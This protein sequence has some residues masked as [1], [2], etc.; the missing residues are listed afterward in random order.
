[1]RIFLFSHWL[2]AFLWLAATVSLMIT[3]FSYTFKIILQDYVN[4]EIIKKRGSSINP[5]IHHSKVF[6]S[7]SLQSII[8]LMIIFWG[9]SLSKENFLM[10]IHILNKMLSEDCWVLLIL[11]N[12]YNLYSINLTILFMLLVR[13]SWNL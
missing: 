4:L 12:L 6:S 5:D 3:V 7:A 13:L 10:V 2:S 1:M 8:R 9:E 11:Y